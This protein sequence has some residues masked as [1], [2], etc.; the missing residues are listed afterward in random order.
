PHLVVRELL[1]V[2][3]DDAVQTRTEVL[4]GLALGVVVV[5]GGC[6]GR[7]G[8]IR[9]FRCGRTRH[10]TGDCD[11]GGAEDGRGLRTHGDSLH[12]GRRRGR[13]YPR[14]RSPNVPSASTVDNGSSHLGYERHVQRA[15]PATRDAGPDQRRGLNSGVLSAIAESR[16]ILLLMP[17][18]RP[19]C[20]ERSARSAART[21]SVRVRLSSFLA[22]ATESGERV[23]SRATNRSASPNGSSATPLA[24]P[25]RWASRPSNVSP[26]ITS[27]FATSAPT[28]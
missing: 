9:L 7:T 21:G 13:S 25:S 26:V 8:R 14:A 15:S 22:A 17:R 27:R 2:G 16:A 1:D 24:S 23:E 28:S 18:S 19:S 20:K 12:D 5:P 10:E 6:V 11:Q 4:A 3:G